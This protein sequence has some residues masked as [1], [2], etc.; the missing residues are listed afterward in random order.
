[1]IQILDI[2]LL[3]PNYL[4]NPSPVHF[5]NLNNGFLRTGDSIGTPIPYV[6]FNY[7]QCDLV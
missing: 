2:R 6:Y 1:M 7:V 3:W 4:R 5:G